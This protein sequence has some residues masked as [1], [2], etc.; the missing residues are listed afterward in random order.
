[1]RTHFKIFAQLCIVYLASCASAQGLFEEGLREEQT[2]NFDKA[3]E[4][5][6]Q[7]ILAD[8]NFVKAYNNRAL[9]LFRRGD[10][11]GA[12]KETDKALLI[13]PE[14]AAGLNN[15]GL[16]LETQGKGQEALRLYEK[17]ASLDANMIDAHFNAGNLALKR[18]DAATAAGY[19]E[20]ANSLKADDREIQLQLARAQL[21]AGNLGRAAEIFTGLRQKDPRDRDA[22]LGL[23][24]VSGATQNTK[25][26]IRLTQQFMSE[27]PDC[28]SCMS[29]LGSLYAEAKD[30]DK[31]IET[32]ESAGK[33]RP[34]DPTPRF[35]L[36]FLYYLKDN[37]DQASRKFEEYLA[38][39]KDQK[40]DLTEKA[41]QMLKNLKKKPVNK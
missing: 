19:L 14:Y 25:E 16:I 39:R 15:K 40:D 38:L 20:T 28:L 21:G 36:G 29:M 7:A 6:D 12:L 27:N 3:L 4:R 5:Y 11:D 32:F 30:Y 35:H 18:G 9:I 8:S 31:A 17:A 22:L 37:K 41:E 1:M 34:T 13:K 24:Q 33:T 2:K 23:I 26:S 10:L